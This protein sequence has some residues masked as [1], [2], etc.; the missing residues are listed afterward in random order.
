MQLPGAYRN[1]WTLDAWT[2]L[3]AW[4]LDAWTLDAWT[5]CELGPLGPKN[6]YYFL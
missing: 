6:S 2:G 1:S 5:F 3:A 4:T